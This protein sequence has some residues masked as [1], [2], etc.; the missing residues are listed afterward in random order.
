M[1]SRDRVLRSLS[2]QEPDRVPIDVGATGSS[3][4]SAIAY[5]A[6]RR[7][8]VLQDEVPYVPTPALF[9]I[10]QQLA[11]IDSTVLDRLHGDARP[12]NRLHHNWWLPSLRLDQWKLGQLTDGTPALVPL[13]FSPIRNGKF[14]ELHNQAGELV[15]K[16]GA[17]GLYYDHVGIYHPLQE[18]RNPKELATLYRKVFP[19]ASTVGEEDAAFVSSLARKLRDTTEHALVL[20]FGASAYEFG[21]YTRGYKQWFLDIGQDKRKGMASC[22]TQLVQE[23]ALSRLQVLLE[24]LGDAIDIVT[25]VDD[26]GTQTGPQ[27]SPETYRQLIK[28]VHQAWWSYVHESSQCRV[29]LH[30]CGSIFDLLPDMIDAGVDIINPVHINAHDMEPQRLKREL[31]KQIVFWGGGCD[32]QHILPFGTPAEVEREVKSKID[33]FAPGGGFVFATVHNVQPDIPPGRVLQVFDTAYEYGG[34]VYGC[35]SS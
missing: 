1:N 29:F 16:R 25:F 13:A 22:L 23:S 34:S 4:L 21:Q 14:Y 7:E 6:L 3:S 26:L 2:H 9:D 31:G 11:S 12:V 19:G 30:S 27:I 35:R 33:A 32:T 10:W 8:L 17:T 5:A 20:Q 24:L 18:A 28:P 15:A